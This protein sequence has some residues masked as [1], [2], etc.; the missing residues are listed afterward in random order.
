MS[1]QIGVSILKYDKVY[2]NSKEE[3]FDEIYESSSKRLKALIKEGVTTIEIKTG[4]G[5]DLQSELKMLEIAK[6]LEENFLIHIEKTFLG[7]HAVPPEYK[8][9]ADD[10]I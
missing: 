10:Y 9:R 1:R 7:A 4:Y 3:S 2:I 8:N 6:K 5:L